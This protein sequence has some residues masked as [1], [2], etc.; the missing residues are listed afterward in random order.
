MRAINLANELLSRGHE[1]ILWSSDFYHQEKRSRY[2]KDKEIII[3]NK[4]KVRLLASSGYRR[5][6]G[7]ARLID[8]YQMARGLRLWLRSDLELP[9]IA[10]IGFPPIEVAFV[11][12]RFMRERGIPT[13][14]DVKDQWPHIFVY[15]SPS[16]IRPLVRFLIWPYFLLAKRTFYEASALSAMSASFLEWSCEFAGR[17]K[18]PTDQVVPLTTPR[19]IS[20]QIKTHQAD[21]WWA[22]QGV[23]ISVRRVVSF[24]GSMTGAM[25]FNV[26]ANIARAAQQS[27]LPVQFVV[28]GD[29]DEKDKVDALLHDIPNVVMPGWIDKEHIHS[30]SKFTL[31]TLVPYR[32]T[33]DFQM[34]IPNKVLDSL[35][36]GLPILTTL[37][38]EVSELVCKNHVGFHGS[39]NDTQWMLAAIRDLVESPTLW[40][41][42]SKRCNDLYSDQFECASVYSAFADE[43]ERMAK[44]VSF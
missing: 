39:E 41:D 4:L 11:M 19:Q 2:G 7:L 25:N 14:L 43:M 17:I 20:A 42:M 1:V 34:S 33:K 5:N 18:T 16:W 36:N 13:I 44:S 22:E 12:N 10:F 23:D 6:I 21:Q 28:C 24:I 38:G 32:N 37:D 40:T 26:I 30:L 31:A 29:G 9:D 8:H 27:Q 15:R 3:S 35:S